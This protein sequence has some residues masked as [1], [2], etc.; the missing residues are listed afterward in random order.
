VPSIIAAAKH[1][2]AQAKVKEL[3]T[4]FV[5]FV[6]I[7]VVSFY[8]IFS[9]FDLFWL[10]LGRRSLGEG[11]VVGSHFWPFTGVLRKI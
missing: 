11:C 9:C 4:V 7:V 8:L 5:N 10:L 2:D 3:I 6:F 1:T